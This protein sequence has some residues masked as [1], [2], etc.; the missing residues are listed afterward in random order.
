MS[1][2]PSGA[3]VYLISGGYHRRRNLRPDELLTSILEDTG[4]RQ[5]S[6]AYVGAASGD[7]RGFFR[8]VADLLRKA[9]AGRVTLA[10]TVSPRPGPSGTRAILS[11]AD[12]VFISG[13]DV[14]EGMR[15]LDRAG[16]NVFLR[17]LRKA[18]TP[19]IGFS[20]GSIM[21]G[22]AWVRWRDPSDDG[23]GERF[24]CLGLAPV[25]CDT[26][27]EDDDWPELKA[28]LGT[29]R[30]RQVAHGLT[31]G[32]ALQVLP[33]GELRSWWAPVHRFAWTNRRLQRLPDLPLV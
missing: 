6:V 19:F 24:A 16:L 15:H 2:M 23:T 29:F 11:D 1:A 21:L 28:L 31:S 30:S 5:P 9:G 4:L 3:S 14:E 22:R 7:D 26:H 12:I 13:G 25:L 20:A 17:R 10:P 33:D 18:G 8:W 32:S 27:E